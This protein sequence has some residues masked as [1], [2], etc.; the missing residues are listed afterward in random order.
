MVDDGLYL[1]VCSLSCLNDRAYEVQILAGQRVVEVYCHLVV[2]DFQHL[3][4]ETLSVLVLQRNDGILVYIVGVELAVDAEHLLVGVQH[5]FCLMLSVCLLLSEREVEVVL[6]LVVESHDGV[7]E[8]VESQ[9]ESAQELEWLFC[10]CLFYH[11]LCAVL[12]CIKLVSY[13]EIHVFLI[14]HCRI[15]NC[16]F[17]LYEMFFYE[18]SFACF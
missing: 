6:L 1:L 16:F 3:A 9:S 11:C 17:C 13:G 10:C 14:F 7:L 4:E 18:V 5:A 12:I 15:Y 2:A 8:V